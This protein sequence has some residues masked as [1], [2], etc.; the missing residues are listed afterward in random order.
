DAVVLTQLAEDLG[1]KA[2]GQLFAHRLQAQADVAVAAHFLDEA[3]FLFARTQ[4]LEHFI[5]VDQAPMLV[6]DDGLEAH[7]G[8]FRHQQVHFLTDRV[9]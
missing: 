7:S 1:V 3:L 8:F 9:V 6:V 5:L 4:E 2:A